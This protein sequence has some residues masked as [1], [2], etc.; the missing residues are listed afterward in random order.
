L[1]FKPQ[2]S[3]SS[4]GKLTIDSNAGN[5]TISVPLS[6]T[7]ALAGQLA[8]T[9][10]SFDFGNVVD[11]ASKT[12][13]ATLSASNGPVTVSAPSI[14]G[15]EFSVTGIS[16]PYSLLA[17]QNVSYTLVFSPSATGSASATVSWPSTASNSPVSQAVAG[18]G[19]PAPSHSV[20]LNWGASKSSN[21]IGY[22]VYRAGQSGGPYTQINSALD[23]STS[24]V[25]V[26]VTAGQS[27]FYVVTA[28]N[29]SSQESAYSNQVKAVVPYP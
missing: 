1:V 8:V 15:R 24:D 14:S 29:A 25:D 26:N 4:L 17:G 3:G 19:T 9:P 28:V 12:Q 22:N 2:A 7:G 5:P 10:S 27:Y 11:G 21:V 6:G 23:T 16:F 20:T 18:T 13:S